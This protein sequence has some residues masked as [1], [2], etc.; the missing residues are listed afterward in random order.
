MI[1]PTNMRLARQLAEEIRQPPAPIDTRPVVDLIRVQRLPKR[2]HSAQE[3]NVYVFKARRLYS[4]T[5][6]GCQWVAANPEE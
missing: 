6:A 1:S 2:F 3:V 5:P 4:L